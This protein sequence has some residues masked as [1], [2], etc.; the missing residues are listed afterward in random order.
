VLVVVAAA[1]N[2]ALGLDPV[3][4]EP[5]DIDGDGVA[6]D[7]CRAVDNPD[8]E[9]T[10]SDGLGDACDPCIESEQL[11]T[12]ADR[13][14]VDDGCDPCLLGRPHDEDGDGIF[15]ACD[16]CPIV[17]NVSQADT[18]GDRVGDACEVVESGASE[19]VFF[20]AFAPPDPRWSSPG[21][22]WIAEQDGF[23][24]PSM[25]GRIRSPELPAL[26]GHQWVVDVAIDSLSSAMRIELDLDVSATGERL[27]CQLTCTS[28]CAF[29][30]SAGTNVATMQVAVPSTPF[31]LRMEEIVIPQSLSGYGLACQI[32][33]I[34]GARLEVSHSENS[35]VGLTVAG[36][37][38]RLRHV[39][40]QR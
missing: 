39:Y 24:A 26:D 34:P 36:Q 28:A 37:N 18:D 23:R 31:R 1:C 8:Q 9:D 19:Q 5:A 10:D 25:G 40:A 27:L 13:D 20:D 4:T 6:Y 2:G 17:G 35:Y 32:V 7:N 33:E 15:D 14:G 16:D 3:A 22:P 12:D 11:F 30:A 21:A 38:I 29:V